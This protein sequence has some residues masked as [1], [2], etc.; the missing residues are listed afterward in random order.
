LT[1]TNSSLK[2]PFGFAGGLY[3][4]DTKLVRFGYRDYD[5]FTGKWTAK[6]PIGFG[7]GDS[8]L[9]GYVWSDPINWVDE[10]GLKARVIAI[11]IENPITLFPAV[12]ASIAYE[13]ASAGYATGYA[14]AEAWDTYQGD[15]SVMDDVANYSKGGNQNKRDSGLSGYS[16][17]EIAQMARDKNIDKALRER[18][19]TEEKA[20]GSRNKQKRNNCE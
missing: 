14:L 2:V 1:D 7:G 10:D 5:A 16:D 20:R 17:A 11:A 18:A 15:Q 3:D 4:E 19:K 8:N 6:D 9:Y 13:S 12:A